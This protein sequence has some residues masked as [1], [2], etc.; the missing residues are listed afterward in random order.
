MRVEGRAAD[1]RA[2]GSRNTRGRAGGLC[3]LFDL[4]VDVREAWPE[5]LLLDGVHDVVSEWR[6]EIDSPSCRQTPVTAE[7]RAEV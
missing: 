5:M 1:S 3:A 6:L 4:F 2:A 7:T